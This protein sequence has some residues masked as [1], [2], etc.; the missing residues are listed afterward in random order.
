MKRISYILILILGTI[1]IM[2][3]SLKKENKP[4]AS[5]VGEWLYSSN[6]S[7]TLIK[8][9]NFF[10]RKFGLRFKKNGK[11]IYNSSFKWCGNQKGNGSK[12]FGHWKYLS[13]TTISISYRDDFG[14][15]NKE[16]RFKKIDANKIIIDF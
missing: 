2:S 13:D 3:N 12:Y 4:K 11:F 7:D 16:C 6:Y 1:L 10:G 8:T 9:N 5:I 15:Q 14:K